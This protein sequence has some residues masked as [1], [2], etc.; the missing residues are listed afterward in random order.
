WVSPT[1]ATATTHTFTGLTPGAYTIEVLDALGCISAVSNHT[2]YDELRATSAPTAVTCNPG[3]IVVTAT[4]G[5]TN[6]VY[7]FVLSGGT[8]T[9][10][11]SNSFTVPL[12]AA[13]DYDVY[14][15]DNDGNA[16]YCEFRETVRVEAILNPVGAATISQPNCSGELGGFTLSITEGQSPFDV[17]VTTT[18]GTAVPTRTG[19]TGDQ[20][21]TNLT[22][23]TYVVTITDANGCSS[24]P[25]DVVIDDPDPLTSSASVTKHTTCTNPTGGEITF[26]AATGG[27]GPNYTYGLNGNYSTDLVQSGLAPGDYVVT[28]RDQNNCELPLGTLTINDLPTE[29][30]L[31]SAV[32]YNCDGTGNITITAAPVGSYTY[33]LGGSSNSTGVFNNQAVG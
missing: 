26:V 27:T 8:P 28:V 19:V 13:G 5:D 1:P 9:F 21:Y 10:G 30:A 15:R 18:S 29:P 4:G 32:A 24:A 14:V 12:G 31:T 17:T 22:S 23:A 33:T 6:Y 7:G 2:I 16:D 20:T 3:S 11:T 25:L